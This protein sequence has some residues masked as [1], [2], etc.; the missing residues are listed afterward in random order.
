MSLIVLTTEDN[1]VMKV[2]KRIMDFSVLLKSLNENYGENM[3]DPLTGIKE[4]DMNLLIKFCDACDYMPIT[5]EKPIWKKTFKNNYITKISNNKKLEQ[6][7]NELD[8]KK[9]CQY[10]KISYFYDSECL[11]E[12]LYFKLY[13][14]F[15]DESKCIDYFKDQDKDTIKESIKIDEDKKAILYNKYQDFI[16]KQVQLLTPEEIEDYCLQCFP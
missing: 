2:D 13:E 3:E 11:K 14:I 7:Y 15:D 1:K 5:F 9:L 6:F 10:F 12:F 4:N 16:Q 8:F